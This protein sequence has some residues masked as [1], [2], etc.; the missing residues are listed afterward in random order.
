MARGG[1]LT[2]ALTLAAAAL[3]S[4]ALATVSAAGSA[5]AP[6]SGWLVYG[7]GSARHGFTGESGPAAPVQAWQRELNGA[8]LTQALVVR[9]V[10]RRGERTVYVGTAA[11]SVFALSG[12]GRVRWRA[13]LGRVEHACK[14]LDEYGVIG[15]PV[16]DVRTRALY[17]ADSHG[18]LHALD[19]VT[20]RERRGWPVRLYGD[21][22]RELVWG[23]LALVGRSVYVPTAAYCDLGPMQGKLIRVSLTTQRVRVW[24]PV[25]AALGGGGGIWGWAG[26]AYSA[27]RGSLFVATSNALPGGSN[28]GAAFREWA[29]HAEHIVELRRD[30]RVRAA[31]HP[32]SINLPRDWGFSGGAVVFAPRGCGELVAAPNKNGRLYVWRTANVARGTAAVVD[33]RRL[34]P[35][36]PL[37]A[38]PAYS[39]RHRSLYVVTGKNLVRIRIDS[40]CRPRTSWATRIDRWGFNGS[41]TIAGR[42]V[43]FGVTASTR[44]LGVDAVSGRVVASRSLTGVTLAAP[45]VID[46]RL[47]VGSFAGRMYAFSLRRRAP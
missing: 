23:A 24:R 8:I 18:R 42:T 13:D 15:T 30:L 17:A 2:R 46:G 21:F 43:W 34:K 19:L 37:V 27:R 28:T 9:G 36:Y 6:L 47:Y 41:P 7:N 39:P 32:P 20:G 29:G 31:H 38:Q 35:R 5:G 12:A 22:R 14:Q 1:R 4:A 44:L 16:V 11:G 25:P 40:R 45:T 3:G 10:P 33:L 26:A